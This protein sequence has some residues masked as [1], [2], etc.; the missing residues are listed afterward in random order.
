MTRRCDTCGETYDDAARST[1]CPHD[2]FLS[3]ADQ[4]QKFLA[5]SL[6]GRDLHWVHLPDG[7]TVRVQS[8]GWRGMV[9]LAGWSGEFAPHLFR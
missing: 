1:I 6:I 2:R 3:E 9:T 4:K 5:L 7:P 8:V